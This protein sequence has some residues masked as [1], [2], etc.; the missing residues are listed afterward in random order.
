MRTAT[1]FDL[2]KNA[3]FSEE[4]EEYSWQ[5]RGKIKRWIRKKKIIEDLFNGKCTKCQKT[6]LV[7]LPALQ[8]H[9][10]D[11][12]KKKNNFS[13]DLRDITD[14]NKIKKILQDENCTCLCSN[15]HS[16][17]GAEIFKKYK[18]KILQTD[19]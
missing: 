9:H 17:E 11:P 2:Y 6:S 15:C 18:N 14:L 12:S 13:A 3:I 16:I 19:L 7:N 8:I 10:L 4:I 1:F 5:I